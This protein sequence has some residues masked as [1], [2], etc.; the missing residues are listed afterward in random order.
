MAGNLD[1]AGFLF[2]CG[3]DAR[4]DRLELFE[5][6]GRARVEKQDIADAD[7]D[8]VRRL[9]GR[10]FSRGDF[11]GEGGAYAL[12]LRHAVRLGRWWRKRRQWRYDHLAFDRQ[13]AAIL[14]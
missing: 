13:L 10:S 12:Q 2:K 3:S 14:Q 7:S 4:C 8:L 9:I 6:G 1:V 5:H 11:G